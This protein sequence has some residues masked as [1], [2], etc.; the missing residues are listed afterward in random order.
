MTYLNTATFG[1]APRRA[2]AAVSAALEQW[3]NGTAEPAGYDAPLDA[4]RRGYAALVGV[5]ADS[6]A[7]GSQASGFAGLVAASLPDDAEV[8]TAA[9][10]FTSIL[11]PF[12]SQQA[13]GVRVREVPLDRLAEQI[14]PRTTLVSVSAVQSADGTVADLAALAAAAAATGTRVLLDVTQAAG[15]LPVD[16]SRFAYT[17]CSGY[18][19][20]LAPRGAAYFTVRPELLDELVP[21]TS[22]WYAGADRWTSIYG[23]PLRL[24]ADARRYDLSP[25][26]HAWVGAAPALDLLAGVGPRALHEHAVRL[27]N[28]FRAGAGLPPG[29]SAIVSLAVDAGAAEALRAARIAGAMRA[30]RLRLSF[31]VYNTEQ[32]ADH[33]AQTLRRYLLPNG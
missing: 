8:L 13:R 21:H 19:W 23:A 29:D 6:V 28:R 17:V 10:D 4:A 14:T 33:A 11:F 20:L 9:G 7:V 27:T 25:V 22:G 30:G 3:R 15:W 2:H 16:A 18:K 24:A 1:L 26:W 32:D 5:P 31:H 12:H